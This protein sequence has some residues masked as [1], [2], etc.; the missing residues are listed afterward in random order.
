MQKQVETPPFL[1]S[2]NAP[3]FGLPSITWG[4]TRQTVSC[5]V[6]VVAVI[7]H[8]AEEMMLGL[9]ITRVAYSEPDLPI[10]STQTNKGIV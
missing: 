6:P 2:F 9:A 4:G 8:S 5:T 10:V 3:E 1:H 7:N